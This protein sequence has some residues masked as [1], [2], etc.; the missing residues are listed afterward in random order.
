MIIANDPLLGN[1]HQ[2]E[3]SRWLNVRANLAIANHSFRSHLSGSLSRKYDQK[4]PPP[5]AD[6]LK[7]VA[8]T[9]YLRHLMEKSPKL[10]EEML[11]IHLVRDPRD[12][13]SSFM[14]WK[15]RKI[16]GKVAHH[17]TPFWMPEPNMLR[18]WSMSKF[19]HF[20]WIWERKNRLFFEELSWLQGYYLYKIEDLRP[21]SEKLEQLLKLILGKDSVLTK[22]EGQKYNSTQKKAFPYW[23]KWTTEQA[24]K[25]HAICSGLMDE[26]GY[27]KELKWRELIGDEK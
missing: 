15:N 20:C 21:G 19:E 5:S 17:L 1:I 18:K 4:L 11:I 6:P 26:Y 8:Y 2:Q 12:F 22:A 14:N 3:D 27:G 24:R 10:A 16:S 23:N 25:L 13:V 7:S 9:F